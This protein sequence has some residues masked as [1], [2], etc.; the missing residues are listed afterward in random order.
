MEMFIAIILTWKIHF[1]RR[2]SRKERENDKW[3]FSTLF[4]LLF[5]RNPLELGSHDTD[6]ET[7]AQKG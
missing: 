2:A 7:K 1:N 5:T 3:G 4:H 6:R